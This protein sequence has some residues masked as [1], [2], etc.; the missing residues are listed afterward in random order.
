VLGEGI[1]H[2]DNCSHAELRIH[3]AWASQPYATTIFGVA[4]ATL[5]F[6]N[7]IPIIGRERVNRLPN[8][9]PVAWYRPTID[10]EDRARYHEGVIPPAASASGREATFGWPLLFVEAVG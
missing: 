4:T 3:I 9:L 5:I 2:G 10:G 1:R 8:P 7:R 6:L